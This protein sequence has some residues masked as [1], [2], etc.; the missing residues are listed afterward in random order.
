[1]AV[2][3]QTQ[4][5]DTFLGADEGIHSIILPDVFSSGGSKNMWTDQYARTRKIDGYNKQNSTKVTIS[6]T[7][8]R[9]RALL[10]YRSTSG[11]S[12]TRQTLG[13]FTDDST[14]WSAFKSTDD[15]ATWSSIFANI[16]GAIN[17][18]PDWAQ[19]GDVGYLTSSAFAPKKWDGTTLSTT[20]RTQSPTVTPTVSGTAGVLI[21]NYTYKL[22]SVYSADGTRKAASVA[23]INANVPSK[24]VTLAW[25]ADTDV[26]V[27]GYEVY[28]TTGTGAVYYFLDYV[29]G[30]TTVAY[31]DNISDLSA[32][33]NRVMEEHGDAPP[34]CHFVEPHKQRMWYGRTSANPTRVYYSDA[35]LPEDVLS[36]HNIDFS[37]SETVGDTLTGM[38][39]NFEG[40]LVVFTEK[41]VWTVS[42]TG[43]VIGNIIDWNRLRSNSETGCP[44][45][46]S[47]TRIP[48]GARYTDQNG[49]STTTQSATIAFWS[50]LG[51][52][53]LFDGSSDNPISNPV[54]TTISTANYAQ[55][56]KTFCVHDPDRWEVTWCFADGSSGEPSQAVTWNYQWGIWYPRPLWGG[57][58]HAVQY[59]NSTSANV[60][61]AGQA[62]PT[63]GGFA[64][65]LWS[66]TS[67]AGSNIN[68]VWMTKALYGRRQDVSNPPPSVSQRKRW[69]WSDFLIRTDQTTSLLVEWMPGKS[70]D[71]GNASGSVTIM[72]SSSSLLS[73]DGS[74]I[75]SLTGSTLVC[76][77]A[78]TQLIALLQSSAGRFLEDEGIRIR[79]SDNST[80]GA[81]SVEAMN[82]AYQ[83]L[84]G[85]K[86]RMDI[87]DS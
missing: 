14:V 22:V 81:W 69:R 57:F 74:T 42:G 30:R 80:N 39:G 4:L 52:I 48:A 35:G 78:T 38:L 72:S 8:T 3:L 58:S 65:L 86:R 31:T 75:V 32:L 46:R 6:A 62:S 43:N 60:L 55:R 17:T 40:R 16:A 23:S 47:A 50:S 11:G 77:Q 29:D 9:C 26:T 66:G 70:Q 59:E 5:F 33:D 34:T 51:D 27:G 79:I 68:A 36:D 49:K 21:G 24:Q 87:G 18:I 1:M 54:Q 13:I 45:H 10:P 73:A 20:G 64:Y 28:R 41:A 53:R 2:P 56:A 82:L 84:E 71:N 12:I 19:F 61:L 85:L 37:D 7:D 83:I 67:A 76:G 15:G 63:T 44:T 25:T